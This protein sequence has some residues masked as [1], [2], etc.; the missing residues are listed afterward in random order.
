M[1]TNIKDILVK[2]DLEAT[3]TYEGSFYV[4]PLQDSNEYARMYTKLTKNAV[5]TEYPSFTTN[6]T[7]AT[8]KI[9]NYFELDVDDMPYN[10]FLIA[11]FQNDKY[12]IRIGEK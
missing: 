7:M 3:G 5:N 12:S 8:T 4:I 11:D 1:I 9:T 2:L 6:T 10:I